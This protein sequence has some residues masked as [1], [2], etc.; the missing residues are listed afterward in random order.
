MSVPGP[1]SHT[2]SAR[3]GRGAGGA[4]K[5]YIF[6]SLDEVLCTPHIHDL[7]VPVPIP[8]G[9]KRLRSRGPRVYLRR[10]MPTVRLAIDTTTGRS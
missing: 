5:T 7:F 2:G 4:T 9:D 10:A 6:M 8:I 1:P 3:S